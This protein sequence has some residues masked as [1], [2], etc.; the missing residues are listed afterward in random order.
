M[1]SGSALVR[2]ASLRVAR[3]PD[4]ALGH[5]LEEGRELDRPVRHR[6]RARRRP[7]GARRDR[8]GRPR[9]RRRARRRS[10]TCSTRRSIVIGG[11]VI[12][13]GEMLLE[14]ARR[15]MRERALLPAR[16]AVRIVAAEFGD[17]AGMIGAALMARRGA[18]PRERPAVV[19]PTP[20][21]NLEDITLRVLSRAA[22]RRRRRVR[23]HAPD[24]RAARALRR[25]GVARALPRAQR[26]RADAGAGRAHARR[27]GRRA[28]VGR[29]HAARLRP[30]LRARA[31]LRRG[32]ARGRGAAGA[33][34][35]A[36]G[37]G[38]VGAAGRRVALR[39]VPAAQARGAGRGASASPET[40]WRSSRPSG[41][42]RRWRVLA[43]SS[44]RRGPS[45]SAAS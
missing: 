31:G 23:G 21:G 6:A 45:R 1:A 28:G 41:W 13:A 25:P 40:V 20:I 9:A 19:C 35:G 5:A 34:G 2:E 24:G 8:D 33:V 36:G 32:G 43:S 30:G 26:A 29:G 17:Q 38:G 3:R 22:R 39:R 15:E 7:G 18:S 16:D 42:R 11:G 14:P 4:T 37:A 10:S 27:R 44:T 12:A